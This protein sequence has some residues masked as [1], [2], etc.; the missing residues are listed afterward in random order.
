MQRLLEGKSIVITGSGR[1]I[2]RAAAELCAQH[3]GRIVVSDIDAKPAEEAAEAIRA[4][5]GEAIGVPGDVT[6]TA[7]P[8]KIV[9]TAIDRFG[10]L[11]VLVNNAGYT[12]DGMSHRMTDQQWEQVLAVHLTAPF[13]MARAASAY[14]RETAKK[15]KDAHGEAK[16]RKIINISS[17]SG[18]RGNFGQA[19]YSAGKAGVVG[20]TKTL[21]K[22]YGMFN[23]QV[24]AIAYGRIETRLTQA[25]EKGETIEREGKTIAL[26][27]P[28]ERLGNLSFIPMGRGGT[29]EEAGGVIVFFASPLSN[30]VSGQVLEVTGGF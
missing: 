4:A 30:Y 18:T 14:I 12:W 15:E 5:G 20:L 29:P 7:F 19:N 27:I 11:D 22:E 10:G 28:E 13:R 26:G 24:N 8:D 16:A 21:A 1:G 17:T 23:V 6:D 2:G 25:K 9:K 3:G